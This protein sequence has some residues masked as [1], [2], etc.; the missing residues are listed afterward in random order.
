[1]AEKPDGV[2]CGDQGVYFA[3]GRRKQ[4][5]A[6]ESKEHSQLIPRY[7]RNLAHVCLRV[8]YDGACSR[9]ICAKMLSPTIVA[10]PLIHAFIKRAVEAAGFYL[11]HLSAA[12]S[13]PT[14]SLFCK[15]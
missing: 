3:V 9:L 11:A 6:L 15:K 2:A 13:H 4:L 1:M 12:L 5:K 7:P 14:D 10:Y 8:L